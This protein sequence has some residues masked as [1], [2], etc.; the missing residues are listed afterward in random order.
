MHADSIDQDNFDGSAYLFHTRC[1]AS[2]L[3]L[4]KCLIVLKLRIILK[5]ESF[6]FVT[7]ISQ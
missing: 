5:I 1:S 6:V 7:S 2:L 4:F 3:T